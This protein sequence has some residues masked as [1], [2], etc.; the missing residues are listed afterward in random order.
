[1]THDQPEIEL[2]D[3]MVSSVAAIT[4]CGTTTCYT[5]N[6]QARRATENVLAIVRSNL[7]LS[8]TLKE[9]K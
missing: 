3:E 6:E 7:A 1:M 9:K 8:T 4:G 5:C 2:T